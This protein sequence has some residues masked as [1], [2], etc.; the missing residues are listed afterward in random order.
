MQQPTLT[1]LA[2]LACLCLLLAS[3]TAVHAADAPAGPITLHAPEGAK[4][5]MPTVTFQHEWHAAQECGACHHTWDG[6]AAIQKCKASGCHDDATTK[7]GDRAYY[8]AYHKPGLQSCLGC[9]KTLQKAKAEAFG[10][11]KCKGCHKK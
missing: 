4:T 9:H 2:T 3:A 1:V 10:P 7:S 11:T 6:A 5:A 8:L